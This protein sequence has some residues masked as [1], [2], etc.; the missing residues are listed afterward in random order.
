VGSAVRCAGVCGFS[1]ILL[2]TATD[3]A[4]QPLGAAVGAEQEI[5]VLANGLHLVEAI[6]RLALEDEGLSICADSSAM[7]TVMGLLV[8]VHEIP[9]GQGVMMQNPS[10]QTVKEPELV[11]LY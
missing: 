11:I 9:R 8:I 10:E 1:C 3:R 4:A 5:S 7:Y 2:R 6:R